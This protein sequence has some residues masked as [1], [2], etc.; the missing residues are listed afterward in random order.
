MARGINKVILIGNI[1]SDPEVK[2]TPSGVAVA[3]FSLATSESWTDKASGQ[4]QERT[5]WH[6]LVLWRKLAEIA[7]QYLKK[8]SKIYVEGKLQTRS[9]DD[10]SGQKRYMTEIVVDDM[11]MLDGR[12]EAGYGGEMSQP[13]AGQP[14]AEAAPPGAPMADDDLPF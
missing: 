6:R 10:A 2:Y 8:G 9:W 1:G 14:A 7:G 12:G 13:G 4:R 11:Q 3:N 5:E